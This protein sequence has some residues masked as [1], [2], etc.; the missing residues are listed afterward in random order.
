MGFGP[1][2]VKRA[3]VAYNAANK[4]QDVPKPPGYGHPAN[5]VQGMRLRAPTHGMLLAS[6][7]ST[8]A[9]ACRGCSEQELMSS[10]R[11]LSRVRSIPV[12]CASG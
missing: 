1:L 6:F 9:T 8:S 2:N 5:E 12:G 11:Y 10:E 7:S 3:S 4:S